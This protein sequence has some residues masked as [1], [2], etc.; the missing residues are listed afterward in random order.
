MSEFQSRVQRKGRKTYTCDVCGGV[1]RPGSEYIVASGFSGRYWQERR[2]I[3]CDALLY[4][5]ERDTG[6]DAGHEWYDPVM[7]WV[8]EKACIGCPTEIKC[9]MNSIRKNFEEKSEIF[10]CKNVLVEVLPG[11]FVK[12]ALRSVNFMIYGE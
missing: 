3:H 1:I 4:A 5:Y 9:W 11:T 10:S 8:R 12:S 2:H 7:G 6:Q